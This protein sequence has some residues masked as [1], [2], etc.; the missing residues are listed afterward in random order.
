MEDLNSPTLSLHDSLSLGEVETGLSTE[1]RPVVEEVHRLPAL[2]RLLSSS[3]PLSSIPSFKP[4]D[5]IEESRDEV[6]EEAVQR[7]ED[8]AALY[9]VAEGVEVTA[10]H[11]A[12]S[13]CRKISK[14]S[15]LEKDS[16]GVYKTE[17][18]SVLTQNPVNPCFKRRKLSMGVPEQSTSDYIQPDEAQPSEDENEDDISDVEMGN[19]DQKRRRLSS[20]RESYIPASEDSQEA[21]VTKTLSELVSLVVQ[22]LS[23]SVE[24]RHSLAL[25]ID[26]SILAEARQGNNQAVDS[27]GGAMVASDLGSTLGSLMHHAPVLRHR[28]VAV[29]FGGLDGLSIAYG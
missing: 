11:L 4:E 2:L 28:H 14:L 9:S 17:Q 6:I 5:S 25:S 16:N 3:R 21:T 20:E 7:L 13:V 24:E 29:S 23:T 19:D 18:L 27:V 10:C 12:P 8:R 22:S 26:D 1:I 15:P